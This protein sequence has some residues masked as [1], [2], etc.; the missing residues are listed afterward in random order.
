M[1]GDATTGSTFLNDLSTAVDYIALGLGA[2]ALLAILGGLA[3]AVGSVVAAEIRTR[4]C[5]REPPPK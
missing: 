3:W 1:P 5:F 2:L 4:Q